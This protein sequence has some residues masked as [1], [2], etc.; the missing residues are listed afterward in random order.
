MNLYLQQQI[1]PETQHLALITFNGILSGYRIF[2]QFVLMCFWSVLMRLQLFWLSCVCYSLIF[3]SLSLALARCLATS[4]H[5]ILLL[6][7]V[8]GSRV[9]WRYRSNFVLRELAM[10][11]II[12]L[13][14]LL[15]SICFSSKACTCSKEKCCEKKSFQRFTE[16][17]VPLT[18]IIAESDF[19]S[20]P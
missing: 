4:L 3:L 11:K 14:L 16:A 15:F 13:F 20:I 17:T 6:E 9:T 7:L 19:L 8:D 18:C 2:L 1:S 12:L 5:I 10:K